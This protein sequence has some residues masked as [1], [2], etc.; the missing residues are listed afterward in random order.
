MLYICNYYKIYKK[1]QLQIIIKF[2]K[3]YVFFKFFICFLGF[4][5]L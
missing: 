2:V 4:I 5:Y 3:K 1:T